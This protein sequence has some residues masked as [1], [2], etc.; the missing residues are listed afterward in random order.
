MNVSQL[1][2]EPVGSVRNYEF[3]E[4]VDVTGNGFYDI[5]VLLNSIVDGKGDLTIQSINEEI[6]EEENGETVT[7]TG[8]IETGESEEEPGEPSLTWLWILIILVVVILIGL[9]IRK[10]KQ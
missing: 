3:K 2:K 1:L 4:S 5:D 8:E 9:G 6:P 10:K 7:T